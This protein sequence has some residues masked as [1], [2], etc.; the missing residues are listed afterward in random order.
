MKLLIIDNY[1]SFTYNLVQLFGEMEGIDVVVRRN[2][3]ISIDEIKKLKPNR[4][5]ISPGPGRPENAG[6]SSDLIRE[7]GKTMP[8]LG[9]CLGH[10]CIAQ[11]FGGEVVRAKTLMHG[12]TSQIHHQNCGVFKGLAEPLEATRY[13][14]LI[15]KR[16][17]LP[18]S[19]QITAETEAGEIMGLTHEKFPIY[20]VQ[21][22]PESILTTEGRKLLANFLRI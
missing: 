15:V 18:D 4:I 11:V 7:F 21:F 3:Q 6:I 17:G 14:S 16:D 8:I 5:C 10:Q 22:H 13:H 1:D 20:G 19:L 12:K 2:D 9:V